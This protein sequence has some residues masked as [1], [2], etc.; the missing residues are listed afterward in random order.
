MFNYI[1]KM[2]FLVVEE[3]HKQI[4]N[5][6][7]IIYRKSNVKILRYIFTNLILAIYL[8][9]LT[10][11][12][13]INLPCLT[14]ANP[15]A[16]DLDRKNFGGPYSQGYMNDFQIPSNTFGPCAKITQVN[17]S[18]N[19]SVT[20]I[21]VPPPCLF[22]N[23]FYINIYSGCPY[24]G[25][26]S[27]P[28]SNIL[29]EAPFGTLNG[30]YSNT[31]NCPFT[32]AMPPDFNQVI[33]VDIVPV[34]APGSCPLWNALISSG[35]IVVDYSICVDVVVD[36]ISCTGTGCLAP[37]T[38]VQACDD[39]N[40][41][42]INDVQTILNCDGSVCVACM[43]TPSG[44]PPTPTFTQLGP[45]CQNAAP[46]VLP[47][48]SSNVPPIVGT[49]SPAVINTAIPGPQVYTFTPNPGECGTT[50]TMTITV[51]PNVLPTFTQLGPYCQNAAADVLPTSS[52]NVPPILGTWSPAI[53]NT[54][55]PGTQV[56]T[57]TPNPGECGTTTSMTISVTPNVLPT[58]TQLG[59]Y[60]QNA[61]PG[62]LTINSTNSPSI[63]GTWSPAIINTSIT[64]TSNYTFTPDPNQCALP[65]TMAI[66]ITGSVLPDFTQ[67]GPYCQNGTPDVL[68][69]IS[70]DS[71]PI[72]GTWSP[73]II[74][75]SI[76]GTSN[77]TF[78]PDPNQCALPTTMAIVI[79][80]SVLPDFTQL[81]PYC[82][83]GTPDVLPSISND[84]QPIIGTWS[85]SIINT[86]IIGSSNY[87]FTPDPNQ[88]AL[89]TTMAIVITGSV[90]PD[91]TQLG[92]YCLNATPGVLPL[93]STNGI[94]GTWSPAVINTATVGSAT[95]TFTPAANQCGSP[96]NMTIVVSNSVAPSFT[97]LGPY[98]LN[99]TP[100]VLPLISANGITGT[101]SP[102]VINTAHSRHCD[103]TFTPAANQCGSP[104]NM[105]IVVSNSVAP[106]F[107]QLGPYCLNATPGV[108][109]LI[110]ANGITGTWSPALINTATVGSATYTFTPAAN[111]CGSP[112][113]MTI[114]VSN[115]VAPSFTQLGPYC[116]N[117][118]PGVLPL[119]SA[120]GITGTWSPAVINT[121]TVGTATYTFTP[122]AN[123]CGSPTNMTIVVSNSVTPSFT[124]LGPYCLNA[125]PGVLPLISANGITG[126][127]S[128]AVINTA[129]VGSATYTFTPAA[130]QCGSPTNMT[131]VVSNSVTPSFTQLG[132]YCLNATPGVLPLISANGIAGTWS[133]AVINTATVGSATYTFTPAA[134][135]CGSPTNMTI[136]VSNSVAPSFTQLGPYCLN[137]TPG[138]LPLISAN[139][140]TGTWSPAVINTAT[141][142]T[143]TYT[144]TPAANQCGSPTNMTIVVSNSVAPSFT[145]LGRIV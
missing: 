145:Q 19:A 51:T 61:A 49:W 71:P 94:T 48:S 63:T 123:Q 73:A 114:V 46:D 110:S 119:I 13:T 10:S 138:V 65:T 76:T 5:L 111:Q 131:I 31:F 85:P 140:I 104:T 53:I 99:A 128:P 115:S 133:P 80:G 134:N 57:F 34:G 139:G 102:A 121:A 58:F 56:Y 52:T 43:G 41:C 95:Y 40:P 37:M 14:Q 64:G 126:T 1:N 137:A 105:T 127:W 132:P 88:C 22:G 25:A 100:G 122:A 69:S 79:T 67:L 17:V 108:L 84:S 36:N 47:T 26:A 106:S 75:T 20:F 16:I 117:A 12:T 77:Y 90:L 15:T 112:T 59:P 81:G 129:S 70:N 113:N 21:G 92:P 120:N 6:K 74:N 9:N 143:A 83:N 3:I 28:T 116:L 136:V 142:G 89:P 97:Q 38:T 54:A 68:P 11:Q 30:T 86:S 55:I 141:V 8:V 32:Q 33:A 44:T 144:F 118:T 18:I 107:T 72:A 2:S 24:G 23:Q 98:C 125:T 101:W 60:C 130:N 4:S 39:N 93:I 66:V 27:C 50:T 91:F 82:Q 35:Y 109:P 29:Y 7:T 62:I 103:I 87:T 135:Q 45:Y 124:Q 42:T 78:T 96:T